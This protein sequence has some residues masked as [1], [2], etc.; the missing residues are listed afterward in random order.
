MNLL[1]IGKIIAVI[2]KL[3]E[4]KEDEHGF[5]NK[6]IDELEKKEIKGLVEQIEKIED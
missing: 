1:V 6:I 3:N 4:L 5:V 2:S